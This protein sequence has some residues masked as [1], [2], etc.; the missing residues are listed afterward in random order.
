[1]KRAVFLVLSA[2][3]LILAPAAA[4]GGPTML[5]GA[6]EEVLRQS[7]PVQAKAKMDLAKLAGFDA[8]RV[9]QFWQPGETK[10]SATDL[11][12][13]RTTANAARLAGMYPFVSVANF[14]SRTTPLSAQDRADFAAYAATLARELPTVH[15]FIVG[16]EPNLNRFWMPQFGET[17]ENLAAPAYVQLLAETYDALKAVSP[18]ITVIG[19]AVSPR[20]VDRPNTGR[21]TH[22]PSTFIPDMGTAYRAMNRPKPIMDVFAFHPYTDYSS[23]P[24]ATPHPNSS[25][26]SIADYDKLVGL[27]GRAFDGTAQSGSTLPILYDEFGVESVIPPAKAGLYT[28][29]EPATTRPVDEATQGEYYRQAIAL[30]FCQQN[31]IGM[32]MF[33]VVDEPGLPAWQSGV[34]YV[35]QTPKSSRAAMRV[36]TGLSRRGIAAR[37]PGMK[38]AV[39]GRIGPLRLRANQ[40][41]FLLGCDIDCNYTARLERLPGAKAVRT[42]TGRAGGHRAVWV[43]FPPRVAAGSYRF[44]VRLVAPVN[45]GPPVT[46]RS[47]TFTRR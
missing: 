38:L 40:L 11:E 30:A 37:C 29:T 7:D 15:D 45:P 28:G 16:N 22:S 35:D 9:T 14:G 47:T 18:E 17:G 1:L 4:A 5:I 36:A 32:L 39:G 26:V 21:D 42:A 33:H 2:F 44:S 13:L 41:G 19:G 6:T 46:L 24:P 27:L 12:K 10:P 8:I 43:L 34:Y 20:G 25:T 3:A 23:Q 31:V